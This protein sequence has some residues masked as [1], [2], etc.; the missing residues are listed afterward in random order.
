MSLKGAIWRLLGMRVGANL[1]DDGCTNPER[2]L[3]TIGD[4]CTANRA[5]ILQGHSQEDGTCKSDRIDNGSGATI[6]CA[7][8]V[9]YGTKFGQGTCVEADSFLKKGESRQVALGSASLHDNAVHDGSQSDHVDAT[10]SNGT[11]F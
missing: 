8:F 1:F 9:H 5:S 11:R 2:S 7:A 3:T 6:G 4:Y 10:S